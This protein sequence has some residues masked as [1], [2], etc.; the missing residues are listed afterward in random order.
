MNKLKINFV[1]FWPNFIKNDNYFF[2]LL[3]TKYNV[4][5]D[6]KDPDLL[7]FSVDFS[8]SN[9]RKKYVNHPCKKIFFTGENVSPNYTSELNIDYPRYLIGKCNYSF[10]FE[11]TSEKNYRLPL[12]VLFINWFNKKHDDNRDI[13][14]HIPLKNF[15]RREFTKKTKFCNFVFSNNQGPRVEIF[16]HLNSYKHVDSYGKLKNNSNFSIPGRGDQKYKLHFLRDYKFTI[17]SENSKADGYT[18]EKII[19]PLSVGSI[20]IYW[21]SELVNQDFN[22]DCFVN[23]NNF[24]NF[25]DVKEYIIEV[26]NNKN[27]YNSYLESPIFVNNKMP[28]HFL[29]EQVLLFFEKKILC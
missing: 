26:D 4:V 20:P 15:F 27:L 19:H 5:I 7:F 8:K 24:S 10:S 18:T 12:W 11:K 17:A 21:G 6:E 1:D 16:E 2:N 23:I 29:P 22:K 28:D 9:E 14:Y 25:D 3:C 13:S